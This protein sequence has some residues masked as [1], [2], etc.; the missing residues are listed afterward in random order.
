MTLNAVACGVLVKMSSTPPML[1]RTCP[2]LMR[3]LPLGAHNIFLYFAVKLYYKRPFYNH[4]SEE[5]YLEEQGPEN[6][7]RYLG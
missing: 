6:S 5:A 3:S 7:T 4:T 2:Y 1:A